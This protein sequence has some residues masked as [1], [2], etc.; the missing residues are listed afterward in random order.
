MH[1]GCIVSA[2]WIFGFS[3][4]VTYCN[5]YKNDIIFIEIY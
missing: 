2:E 3:S 5:F 1:P 4:L